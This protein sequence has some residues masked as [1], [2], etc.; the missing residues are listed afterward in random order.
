VAAEQVELALV[1]LAEVERVAIEQ[2]LVLRLHQ[3]LQLQLL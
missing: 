3:V 2:R 1:E